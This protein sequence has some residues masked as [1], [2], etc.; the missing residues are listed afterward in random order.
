MSILASFHG[1]VALKSA[2]R[3]N[4]IKDTG[5]KDGLTRH[6]IQ[7]LAPMIDPAVTSEISL[8]EIVAT[9]NGF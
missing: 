9:S 2:F 8:H 4:Q 1:A 3:L 5:D 6:L 7:W